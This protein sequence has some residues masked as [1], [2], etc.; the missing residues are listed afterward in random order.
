M[1]HDGSVLKKHTLFV[2]NAVFTLAKELEL[3]AETII[4]EHLFLLWINKVIDSL[5]VIKV[6]C[7]AW[8]ITEKK[9]DDKGIWFN[10]QI[11]KGS[12]YCVN[13]TIFYRYTLGW[14][15]FIGAIVRKIK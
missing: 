14:P 3:K 2:L 1:L 7:F 15:K 10:V 11:L 13:S 6:I 4:D 5:N 12:S 9:L 8:A